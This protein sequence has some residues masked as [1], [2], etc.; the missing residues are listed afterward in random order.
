[1]F[2]VIAQRTATRAPPALCGA[3]AATPKSPPP[4]ACLCYTSRAQACFLF[5]FPFVRFCACVGS[6]NCVG[7]LV[8]SSMRSAGVSEGVCCCARASASHC[9][10]CVCGAPASPTRAFFAAGSSSVSLVC[11]CCCSCCCFCRCCRSCG[12]TLP[13]SSAVMFATVVCRSFS[14]SWTCSSPRVELKELA[15][16]LLLCCGGANGLV[17]LGHLLLERGALCQPL[18]RPPPDLCLVQIALFL[19]LCVHPLPVVFPHDPEDCNNRNIVVLH[20]FAWSL[21]CACVRT[22]QGPRCGLR[23]AR[24]PPRPQSRCASG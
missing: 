2:V 21:S 15:L 13:S 5:L 19:E 8:S 3:S 11:C 4:P 18:G 23:T 1:M 9:C 16:R 14:A 6:T 10:C 20:L 17:L 22:N 7:V 12:L 24:T